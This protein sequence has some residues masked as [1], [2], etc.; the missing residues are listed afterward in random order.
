MKTFLIALLISFSVDSFANDYGT[1]IFQDDFERSEA[2][3][4]KEDPGNGWISNSKSRA[5]GNKQLDLREGALYIYTHAE[6]DHAA[7]AKHSIGFKNGTISMKIKFE[8]SSDLININI[9]DSKEKSVHAGH[10]FN[11]TVSPS[12]VSLTDLKTGNM[13]LEIREA[14]KEKKL[15]PEQT[16]LLKTKAKS[17]KQDLELNK[18][19][20]VVATIKGDEV[21]CSINGKAIGSFKSEGFAHPDKQ[22]MRLIVNKNVYVDDIKVWKAE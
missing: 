2:D 18:W 17:F 19:H 14:K 21:S 5:K 13:K 3:D 1:L 9:A 10:L 8:A 20:T 15:S 4:K 6:A 22:E 12:K 16:K 11:V 7:V